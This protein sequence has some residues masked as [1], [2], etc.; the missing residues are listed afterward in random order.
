MKEGEIEKKAR[1]LKREKSGVGGEVLLRCGLH[2]VFVRS[3]WPGFE[4]PGSIVP[5]R[6]L[7]RTVENRITQFSLVQLIIRLFG[8]INSPYLPVLSMPGFHPF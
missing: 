3:L 7:L 5:R 6:G 1:W 2:L 4:V 8:K